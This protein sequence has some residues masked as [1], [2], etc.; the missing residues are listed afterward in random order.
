MSPRSPITL[1]AVV[2]LALACGT[3]EAR[4]Q[5]AGRDSRP[6]ILVVMTDDMA[7]SDVA[8]MPN[9]KRLLAAQGTTFGAGDPRGPA[10]EARALPRPLLRRPG[11]SGQGYPRGVRQARRT[12]EVP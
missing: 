2:V 10:R 1:A 11:L 4:P 6:N 9:V 5:G 12:A 7:S 8:R 3:A